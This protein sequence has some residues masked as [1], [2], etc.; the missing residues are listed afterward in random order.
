M[1][2]TM[3]YLRL[4]HFAVQMLKCRTCDASG[5]TSGWQY[6]RPIFSSGWLACTGAGSLMDAHAERRLLGHG[7]RPLMDAHRS[8]PPSALVAWIGSPAIGTPEDALVG[9]PVG[10]ER[11][12]IGK[13][14]LP[15]FIND[16]CSKVN[17]WR[18]SLDT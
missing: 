17:D 11:F 9:R 2:Y 6:V 5:P 12:R 8:S 4:V 13:G 14:L 7:W 10:F 16:W 1:K 3:P 18:I 15:R